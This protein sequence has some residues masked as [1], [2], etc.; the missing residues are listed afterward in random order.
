MTWQLWL[1]FVATEGLL[2]ITPGPA[3]LLVMSQ[4][5]TRGAPAGVSATLGVLAGNAFYFALSASSLGA[6]IAASHEMF[7]LIKW[8]GAAYL[9]WLGV[10]TF[11]GRS[12]S[13]SVSPARRTQ[14][15]RVFANGV[16][17][18]LANPKALLFFLALLP[19][20][21][22]PAGPIVSQIVILGVTS[23]VLEFL[24]LLAYST[25][26]SRC[27]AAV[28]RSRFARWID[29]MAGSCLIGAGLLTAAIRRN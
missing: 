25:A 22:D 4:A 23:V 14:L 2:C 9:I 26:A 8:F 27:G 17:L 7:L 11:R 13:F 10:A 15:S 5:L 29:R 28:M 24:A 3:V 19:Q 6:L 21:I 20:F 1:V 12:S 16:A 18:Q